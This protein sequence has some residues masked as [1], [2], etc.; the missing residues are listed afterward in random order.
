MKNKSLIWVIL[1]ALAIVLGT[2][3]KKKVE[4]VVEETPPPPPLPVEEISEADFLKNVI[5]GLV[6]DLSEGDFLTIQVPSEAISDQNSFKISKFP[7][8]FTHPEEV[9]F[10]DK[11]LL[12]SVV[13]LGEGFRLEY[14]HTTIEEGDIVHILKYSGVPGLVYDQIPTTLVEGS[15]GYFKL[16][17]QRGEEMPLRSEWPYSLR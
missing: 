2:G 9:K 4:E 8:E 15:N 1:F 17:D 10:V 11:Y 13:V 14:F 3:C 12:P 6:Y 16:L 7:T 5:P